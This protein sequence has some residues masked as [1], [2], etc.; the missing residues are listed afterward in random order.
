MSSTEALLQ[1]LLQT[2]ARIL[3][4]LDTLDE[5]LENLTASQDQLST[6]VRETR[7]AQNDVAVKVAAMRTHF[8]DPA[9]TRLFNSPELLKMILLEVVDWSPDM[10]DDKAKTAPGEHS[11]EDCGYCHYGDYCGWSKDKRFDIHLSRVGRQI[12]EKARRLRTLLFARRVS[13]AFQA[14]I[15]DSPKLQR[16]LFFMPDPFASSVRIN[17]LYL[18]SQVCHKVAWKNNS[19]YLV[20]EGSD[21]VGGRHIMLEQWR[22]GVTS[23]HGERRLILQPVLSAL[24]ICNCIRMW[25]GGC[26]LRASSTSS[27]WMDMYLS[28]PSLEI[29]WDQRYNVGPLPNR[30]TTIASLF[31]AV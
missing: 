14:T 11:S 28:Q 31:S 22:C 17:W 26:V 2:Q 8:H 23:W 30:P 20:P 19:P 29:E 9:R 16:A 24:H 21:A 10:T 12:D 7:E 15:D 27:S 13:K 18:R 4:R 1:Q 25:K 5:K 6:E 3:T